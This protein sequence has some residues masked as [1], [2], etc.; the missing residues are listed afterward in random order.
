MYDIIMTTRCVMSEVLVDGI[1]L[2]EMGEE[3]LEEECGFKCFRS[4]ITDEIRMDTFQKMQKNRY[5][6]ISLYAALNN[7][8]TKQSLNRRKSVTILHRII[9]KR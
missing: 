5:F 1:I 3:I 9:S 6:K 7:I 4:S 8:N 2:I